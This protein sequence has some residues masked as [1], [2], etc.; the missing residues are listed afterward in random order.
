MFV[1]NTIFISDC[2]IV[3]KDLVYL[4]K[5]LRPV[6]D[7]RQPNQ[8]RFVVMTAMKT[9]EHCPHSNHSIKILLEVI[10]SENNPIYAQHQRNIVI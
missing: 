8:R 2:D 9:I 7:I 6:Q 5:L 4:R 1:F 3:L 10:C